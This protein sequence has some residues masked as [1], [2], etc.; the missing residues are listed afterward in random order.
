MRAPKREAYH[1]LVKNPNHR[2]YST[3]NQSKFRHTS[4]ELFHFC[5]TKIKI[6]QQMKS[7]PEQ[8]KFVKK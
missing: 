3:T 4:H 5:H 2:H 8:W 6:A 1:K 7:E